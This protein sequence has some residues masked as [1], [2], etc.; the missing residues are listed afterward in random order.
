MLIG[1]KPDAPFA[2]PLAA[3]SD[4]P[5]SALIALDDEAGADPAEYTAG[6]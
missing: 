4:A 3:L 2:R 5:M 1:T 6:W